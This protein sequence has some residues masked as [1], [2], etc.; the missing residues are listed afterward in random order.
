MKQ[1]LH[2]IIDLFLDICEGIDNLF[3][4]ITRK[5]KPIPTL[6]AYNVNWF[7]RCNWMEQVIAFRQLDIYY[8]NKH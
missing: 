7:T 3:N 6:L 5:P 8:S 2:S 1:P 4:L